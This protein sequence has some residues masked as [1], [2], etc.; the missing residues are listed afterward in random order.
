MFDVAA[1][2]ALL[3]P[4]AGSLGRWW[5]RLDLAAHFQIFYLPL[6]VAA[7]AWFGFKRRRTA[8]AVAFATLVLVLTRVVPVFLGERLEAADASTAPRLRLLSL[9]VLTANRDKQRVLDF[10][11]RED[12]D[13]VFLMEVDLL[14]EAAL[15]PLA[16]RYPHHLTFAQ[17]DNFGLA[18]FSRVPATDLKVIHLGEAGVPTMTAT[19][20]HA[21]R[22]LRFIGT[23]PV[24][25]I[26]GQFFHWQR[27][28][29]ALLADHVRG[30]DT[31]VLL[32]CDLNSTPWGLVYR[33]FT[34][35]TGLAARSVDATWPATWHALPFAGLPIDHVLCSRDLQI[36][37]RRVGPPVGSDHRPL[38]A[39]LAWRVR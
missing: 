19:L 30:L 1:W 32:A 17:E 20:R 21:G 29:M 6:I 33:E 13:V 14:W 23:H 37:A 18:F 10:I 35:T 39:E 38:T 9:N 24:P 31:P 34:G 26:G 36:T 11:A 8:A 15:A 4:W 12:A 5:W 2:L 7:L 22:E 25:P 3:G 28:Q 16:A 27:E